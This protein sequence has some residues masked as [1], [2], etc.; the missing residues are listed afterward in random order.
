VGAP[1]KTQDTGREDPTEPS[2]TLRD[3]LREDVREDLRE[4]PT[5]PTNHA[6]EHTE[7]MGVREEPTGPAEP[8]TAKHL[9]P[10]LAIADT[11]VP[12]RRRSD[13]MFWPVAVFVAVLLA[14]IGIFLYI[15]SRAH[16]GHSLSSP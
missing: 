13:P 6:E 5:D 10:W 12:D 7:R 11:S 3:D 1:N 9:P 8:H 16:V 15:Q 4:D 14:G 2:F